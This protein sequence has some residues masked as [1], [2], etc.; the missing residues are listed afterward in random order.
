MRERYVNGK[1]VRYHSRLS[2]WHAFAPSFG[3]ELNEDQ[4]LAL[5]IKR[6]FVKKIGDDQFEINEE[7]DE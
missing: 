2:L 4:L 6:G 3:F 1:K 7:Y 5:A